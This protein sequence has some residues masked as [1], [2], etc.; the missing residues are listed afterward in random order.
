MAKGKGEMANGVK[1]HNWQIENHLT[2]AI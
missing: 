1:F 2:F